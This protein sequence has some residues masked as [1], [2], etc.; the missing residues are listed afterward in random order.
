MYVYICIYICI[1]IH[2]YIYKNIY[3]SVYLFIHTYV[4]ICLYV[5]IRIGFNL[6]LT[7]AAPMKPAE[8]KPLETTNKKIVYK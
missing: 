3:L 7:R 1:H 8:R 2:T 4:S 6:R 5:Y